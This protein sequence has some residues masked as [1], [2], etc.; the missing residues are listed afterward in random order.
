MQAISLPGL[1]TSGLLLDYLLLVEHRGGF[2][3][4]LRGLS[5]NTDNRAIISLYNTNIVIG[6][7]IAGGIRM[8]RI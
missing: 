5:I 8:F 6:L 2:V 1:I 3:E 4:S 7:G